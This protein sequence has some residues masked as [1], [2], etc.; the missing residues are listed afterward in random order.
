MARPYKGGEGFLRLFF[1]GMTYASQATKMDG[2][3]IRMTS[4]ITSVGCEYI[5]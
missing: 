1:N 4:I 3:C 5:L 2:G